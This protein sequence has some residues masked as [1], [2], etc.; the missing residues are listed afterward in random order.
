MRLS[1]CDANFYVEYGTPKQAWDTRPADMLRRLRAFRRDGSRDTSVGNL[2]PTPERKA[3][4]RQ[5]AL[6]V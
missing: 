4:G 5:H 1:L 6:P 2:S 3:T